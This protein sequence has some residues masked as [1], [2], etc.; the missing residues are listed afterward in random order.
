ML[1]DS[2]EKICFENKEV[3]VFTVNHGNIPLECEFAVLP[4]A[5]FSV[6]G[7]QLPG[8]VFLSQS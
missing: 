2:V 4:Q 7:C 1:G 6:R 5:A 3:K 8:N